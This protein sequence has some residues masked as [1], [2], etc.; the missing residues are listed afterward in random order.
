[1]TAGGTAS[2]SVTAAGSAPL[3]YLWQRNGTNIAGATLSSY[4]T[5]T[6]QLSDSG[7]VF[8][9]LVSNAYGSTAS[10]NATLTV[11]AG[12]PG[13]ITFDDLTGTSLPVPAGY[14]N[15]TWSNFYY[16]NGVAYGQPSGFAAGVV[17]TNN[18]AYNNGGAPAAISS[19]APFTLVSAYL[20]AAWNDNLQ[21]EVQGYNGATLSYDNTYTLERDYSDT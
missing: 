14:D 11:V 17:S 1:M 3:S 9:C 13:L 19:S 6:V 7:T 15:L 18:V 4:M 20:T 8:S 5:N 16:L 12:T 21:V 10:S 2:F